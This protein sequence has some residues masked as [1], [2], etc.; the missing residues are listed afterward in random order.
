M[1][2]NA[3]VL[4]VF[5]LASVRGLAADDPAWRAEGRHVLVVYAADGADRDDSGK[6]DSQEAAEYYAARRSVPAENLLGVKL[7]PAGKPPRSRGP[8]RRS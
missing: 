1:F 8:G 6:P 5:L 2:R 3:T 7:R 4:C